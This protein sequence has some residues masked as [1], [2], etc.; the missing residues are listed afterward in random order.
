M[1]INENFFGKI[2]DLDESIQKHI[3]KMGFPYPLKIHI[4]RSKKM[5]EEINRLLIDIKTKI[6]KTFES[7]IPYILSELTDNIEQ[8]SNYAEAFLF[9][10]YDAKEKCL[11][12]G[13]FDD[14]LSIP[15]VFEKNNINYSK[16][17]DAIKMAL[18]GKTTKQED[19]SRGFGLR[20]TRA[21]VK[22]LRGEIKIISR[23]GMLII[24]NS[25]IDIIDFKK[26]KLDGTM[27]YLKLK[28]PEKDLNIYPY[29]E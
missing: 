26:G 16:D 27:I 10:R 18:E 4:D 12:I 28:T 7:S 3:K 29:L 6:P 24:S 8:H 5:D 2:N 14:G 21:I 1:A 11:E 20:T 15:V 25:S 19:I 17:S 23:E 22:A 13:V 9:V